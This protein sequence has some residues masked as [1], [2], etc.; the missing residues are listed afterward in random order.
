MFPVQRLFPNI[1][2][3]L[4]KYASIHIPDAFAKGLINEVN[5]IDQECGC[6]NYSFIKAA[7]NSDG[8]F[9]YE[10]TLS[11][12]FCQVIWILCDILLRSSDYFTMKEIAEKSGGIEAL[13][14]ENTDCIQIPDDELIKMFPSIIK[15]PADAKKFRNQLIRSNKLLQN[16]H[17]MKDL[18]SELHLAVDLLHSSGATI[19]QEDFKS[20]DM[21]PEGYG[22]SVNGLCVKAISFVLLHEL[23][24]CYLE[25]FVTS[26]PIQKKE[27]DAD[28]ETLTKMYDSCPSEEKFTVGVALLSLMIVFL[29][30]NPNLKDDKI[31]PRD[32]VRLFNVFDHIEKDDPK[33]RI[34]LV[35]GF[36]LWSKIFKKEDSPAP[37]DVIN[38]KSIDMIRDYFS[39]H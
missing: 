23:H 35:H 14:K 25:H 37:L 7:Q 30:V 16:K 34:M 18:E 8:T 20:L 36:N 4:R 19:D 15:N 6:T 27:R 26:E 39:N 2:A 5:V 21:E 12:A 13:I 33:Y 1:T 10:V 24:H 22:E 3:D 32:D 9:N 11:A 17:L 31:H 28:Q 29:F 38:S